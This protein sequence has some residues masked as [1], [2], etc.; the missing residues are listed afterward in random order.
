MTMTVKQ[1]QIRLHILSTLYTWLD[2]IDLQ[3]IVCPEVQSTHGLFF[4]RP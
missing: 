4:D 2:V 1:L 3:P